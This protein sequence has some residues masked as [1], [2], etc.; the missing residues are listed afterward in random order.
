MWIR[1]PSRL[2]QDCP[3]ALL[4]LQAAIYLLA[5]GACAGGAATEGKSD[6]ERAGESS[7]SDPAETR[8]TAADPCPGAAE[9]FR[10]S[11]DDDGC[12]DGVSELLAFAAADL[13]SFWAATMRATSLPYSEPDKV[14]AYLDPIATTCGQ[15]V[16]MNAF[17][18]PPEH[19]IF[20]D[21]G[22]AT[23]LLENIGDFGAVFVLA[24]EWGH[25]LQG[26]LGLLGA[27]GQFNIELELQADCLAGVY[28]ASANARGLLERGDLEEAAGALF[29]SGD[30][31]GTPW[32]DPQAHGTV[33]QRTAAFVSG[34]RSG[35]AACLG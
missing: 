4:V 32:Y 15:T 2:G 33:E 30:P 21:I 3:L 8:Q 25:L 10:W 28:A 31:T 23:G 6:G 19:A 24:H 17:Y 16:P 20:Y 11:Q 12:P 7:G 27:S 35:L 1:R 22:L 5:V 14:E 13:D 34:Y 9:D 26:N 29:I 18:C